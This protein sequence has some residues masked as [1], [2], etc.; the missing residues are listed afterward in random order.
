[1]TRTAALLLALLLAL[2]ACGKVGPPLPAGPADK[3][4]WPRNYPK[5]T[6]NGY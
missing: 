4:T 2:A 1:M 5:P 3:I 6:T